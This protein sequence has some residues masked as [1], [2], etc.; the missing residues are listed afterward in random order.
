LRVNK[1]HYTDN[2]SSLHD[3][4]QHLKVCDEAFIPRLSS[5]VNLDAYANK[6]INNADRYEAWQGDRLAGLIAAYC[7][8]QD[9]RN[10]FITNVSVIPSCNGMG[11]ANKLMSHCIQTLQQHSFKQIQL[12]VAEVNQPAIKLYQ[13]FGFSSECNSGTSLIMTLAL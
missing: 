13:K 5:R 10:A 2:K 1:F 11:I 9:K 3:V 8:A 6:I 4:F 12:Q 7:N